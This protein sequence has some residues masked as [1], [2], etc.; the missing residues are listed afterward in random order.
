MRILLSLVLLLLGACGFEPVYGER[1][2]QPGGSVRQALGSIE[3]A[4]VREREG[5]VLRNRLID[6]LT[7]RGPVA[8]PRYALEVELDEDVEGFAIRPDRAV[9]RERVEVRARMVLVDHTTGQPVIDETE[10]VWTSYD[11]VQSDFAN[12]NAQR[13]ARARAAEQ[14]ADRIVMRLA[15]YLRESGA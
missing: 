15:T 12:I 13:D 5:Q 1:P 7:P 2:A 6:A 4:Q 11:I 9:T 10:S 3:I 8:A 14:L